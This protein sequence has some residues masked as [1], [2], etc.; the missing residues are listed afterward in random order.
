M[1]VSGE[2]RVKNNLLLVDQ[3]CQVFLEEFQ[4]YF[5][6]KR[7]YI[8]SIISLK[9]AIFLQ[10]LNDYSLLLLIGRDGH[11]EETTSRANTQ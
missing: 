10:S 6:K 2:S 1:V 9:T 8:P 11:P 4:D 3:D 5:N 7:T